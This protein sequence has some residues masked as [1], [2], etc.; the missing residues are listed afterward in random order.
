[1]RSTRRG[2]ALD[3]PQTTGGGRPYRII[4]GC[5]TLYNAPPRR[6]AQ[7]PLL[8]GVDALG[9]RGGSKSSFF[10]GAVSAAD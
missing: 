6:T 2:V 9:R 4:S 5:Y 7:I 3:R 1:M 10:K 8:G